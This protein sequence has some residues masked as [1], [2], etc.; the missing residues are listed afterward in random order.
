[1][2]SSMKMIVP[3][4]LLVVLS[5]GCG[6]SGQIPGLPSPGDD[7]APEVATAV[8]GDAEPTVEE[9]AGSDDQSDG[10]DEVAGDDEG[11]DQADLPSVTMGLDVLD[12]YVS[13]FKMTI[14]DSEDAPEGSVYAM[15]V[16]FVRDPL[17]Q[18]VEIRSDDGLGRLLSVR[19]GDEQYFAYGDEECIVSTVGAD[20]LPMGEVFEPDEIVG[21]ISSAKRVRPNETINGIRCEHYTFDESAFGAGQFTRASGDAWIAVDGDYVVK[22]VVEAEG[23]NPATG[24]DGTINLEYEISEVNQPLVIEPPE[25]CQAL[26]EIDLPIM[27]DAADLQRLAGTI[28]YTSQ[29]AVEEVVT[30]YREQMPAIGWSEGDQSFVSGE[31]AMLNFSL[32]GGTA[33]VTISADDGVTTVAIMTE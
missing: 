15:R 32:D 20:E 12:S 29:S 17:A 6:L 25:G 14:R 10:S 24:E 8:V 5:L 26:D 27:A 3:L 31:V 13:D 9:S 4:C 30:F 7:D 33:T 23:N 19:V 28:I 1:V 18:R 16:E 21:D 11:P 22:F 2:H